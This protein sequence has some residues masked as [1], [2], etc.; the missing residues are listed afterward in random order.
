MAACRKKHERDKTERKP[1]IKL[2]RLEE[3]EEWEE[4]VKIEMKR[5]RESAAA[6][7]KNACC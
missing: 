2:Q 5:R 7:Q 1:T 4:V 6:D 3:D